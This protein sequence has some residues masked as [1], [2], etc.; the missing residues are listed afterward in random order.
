MTRDD[1]EFR[2]EEVEQDLRRAEHSFI[3][4][5]ELDIDALERYIQWVKT[6]AAKAEG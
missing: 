4:C 5:R 6:K 2:R 3:K 1:W